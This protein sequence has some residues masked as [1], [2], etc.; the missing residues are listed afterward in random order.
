MQ[1]LAER[2]DV[3]DSRSDCM[4]QHRLRWLRHL[5]GMDDHRLLKQI[6][7]AEGIVPRPRHGPKKRW[8]DSLVGGLQSLGVSGD[9]WLVLA[10][11]REQ[12]H[13]LQYQR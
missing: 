11:E 7:L 6:L 13:Q 8:R 5:S 9:D 2:L 1:E 10:Q 3:Q 12:W 4:S